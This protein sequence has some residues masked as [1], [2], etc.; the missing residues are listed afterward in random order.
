[1]NKD[2]VSPVQHI[3][4]IGHDRS[5]GS[6]LCIRYFWIIDQPGKSFQDMARMKTLYSH[7]FW[8]KCILSVQIGGPGRTQVDGQQ[9]PCHMTSIKPET[10]ENFVAII[11]L[12]SGRAQG[13]KMSLRRVLRNQVNNI[14]GVLLLSK[15]QLHAREPI[16]SVSILYL[17]G[18]IK[19]RTQFGDL[20]QSGQ[21]QRKLIQLKT[22]SY[23]HIRN[24]N[25]QNLYLADFSLGIAESQIPMSLSSCRV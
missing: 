22:Q 15:F 1:M 18:R 10:G 16:D 11:K 25:K 14:P 21:D 7:R 8:H 12:T 19:L 9:T 5:H 17:P 24:G 23:K 2:R 20:V 13:Y 6:R 3:G 4:R